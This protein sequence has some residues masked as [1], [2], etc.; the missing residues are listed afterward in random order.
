M[1]LGIMQP[2]LFPYIGYWQLINIVDVFVIYDDVNFIKQGYI[3]K[4]NILAKDK[5]QP[6][7]LELIGASSN[8]LINEVIIGNNSKKILKTIK[9]NYIKA[10]HF[11]VVFPLIEDILNNKESDL[12]KFIGYSLFAI[13]NFL[14]IDTKFIYSSDIEKNNNLKA[15]DKVIEI[16]NNLNANNYINSI[17]GKEL[18]SK[19][20]FNNHNID[21]SFIETN[22]VEYK[23]Y[24]NK[25]LPYLSIVDIMMFN[26]IQTIST[27]LKNYKLV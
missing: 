9:Q 21:L 19:K 20:D 13:S 2:Y 16:C 15:Q 10:P 1:T 17:G 11:D 26:D 22:L 23:Q 27:Y 25:F 8:K 12:S 18:Y 4:N 3:N 6:F 24:N 14:E 5:A 7:T